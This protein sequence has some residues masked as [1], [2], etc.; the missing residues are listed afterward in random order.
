MKRQLGVLYFQQFH[1]PM[2]PPGKASETAVG[3][4]DAVARD[5]HGNGIGPA[6]A[7]DGAGRLGAADSTGD[8][9]PSGT[10]HAVPK[11]RGAKRRSLLS[12]GISQGPGPGH[13]G[14]RRG[15]T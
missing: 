2:H 6:S 4:N 12:R 3:A 8:S 7:A 15:A 10:A 11:S 9:D 1:L 5:E 14:R 13:P